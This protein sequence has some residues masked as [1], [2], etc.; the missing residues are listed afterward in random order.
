[1]TAK[2]FYQ[3]SNERMPC[4]K[5]GESI[6]RLEEGAKYQD[7]ILNEIKNDVKAIKVYLEQQKGAGKVIAIVA[8][9]IGSA[10]TFVGQFIF[11]GFKNT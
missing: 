6:A 7:A 10:F 2:P 5:H 8:G 4:Q 3:D 1:M 11:S 9:L